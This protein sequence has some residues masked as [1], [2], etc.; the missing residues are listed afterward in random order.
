MRISFEPIS[1]R[2]IGNLPAASIGLCT[3]NSSGFTAP[4]TTV[5]PSPY[6]LVMKTAS[7]KPDS[8][9]IVNITP[10]L[11]RSLRTMRWMPADSATPACAKP[12]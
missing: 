7:G 5:S 2:M 6:E 4:C 9:S 12:L 3:K 11:P 10:E 1:R 8:V